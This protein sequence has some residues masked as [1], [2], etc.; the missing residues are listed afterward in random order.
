MLKDCISKINIF[1]V[2]NIN[3]TLLSTTV[4]M[5]FFL[6]LNSS[7]F[8]EISISTGTKSKIW[9]TNPWQKKKNSFETFN[10]HDW[11]CSWVTKKFLQ[12]IFDGSFL[13][14][15]LQQLVFHEAYYKICLILEALY[16][17]SS[18]HILKTVCN[19]CE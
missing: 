17:Q 6:V 14:F 19:G 18:F 2:T 13:N 1:N 16:E 7:K 9:D 11:N 8:G 3:F 10:Y 15:K 12:D 5:H 4:V